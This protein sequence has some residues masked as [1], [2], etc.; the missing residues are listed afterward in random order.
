MHRVFFF[1]GWPISAGPTLWWVFIRLYKG[2]YHCDR[3]SS[4]RHRLL[5]PPPPRHAAYDATLVESG[6]ALGRRLSVNQ[7]KTSYISNFTYTSRPA[8]KSLLWTL[9]CSLLSFSTCLCMWVC[10]YVMF[11]RG[12]CVSLYVYETSHEDADVSNADRCEVLQW[13]AVHIELQYNHNVIPTE[14][15]EKPKEDK[16]MHFLH[17]WLYLILHHT[18]TYTHTHTH[19]VHMSRSWFIT[20][21]TNILCDIEQFIPTNA[22]RH[23]MSIVYFI[24]SLPQYVFRRV[25]I[26]IFRWSLKSFFNI[27]HS[28]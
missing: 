24:N 8:S 27:D 22:H 23:I 20:R 16:H 11:G 3:L 1:P 7:K 17:E 13:Q 10:T 25:Y 5:N 6:R 19:R 12:T 4:S 26:A 28:L 14:L 18:H 15:L 9:H 2:Y 21:H